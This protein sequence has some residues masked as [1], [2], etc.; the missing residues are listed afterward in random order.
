[1]ELTVK[2]LKQKEAGRGLAAIDREVMQKRDWE[3][4]NFV[5]IEGD[6]RTVCRIWPGYPEDMGQRIIRVDGNTR[7]EADVGIDDT[8][9]VE[10]VRVEPAHRVKLLL[11]ENMRVKGRIEAMVRDQIEGK[12]VESGDSVQFDFSVGISGQPIPLAVAETEPAGPV[13]VTD[14]TAVEV[15][16]QSAEMTD[17]PEG[18][19]G[20]SRDAESDEDG[21]RAAGGML[22][23]LETSEL[24]GRP[25]VG[26]LLVVSTFALVLGS[27]YY[28]DRVTPTSFGIWVRNVGTV[29]LVCFGA[30]E[31][32]HRFAR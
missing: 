10:R 21:E 17:E 14:A 2:P 11:P 29:V 9:T 7:Q 26:A 31:F 32:W 25:A 23:R 22:D 8:V 4:G 30:L 15:A 24:V 20:D 16:E 27:A 13:I 28:L 6:S 3:N 19:E 1:M 18:D 5:A 12:V